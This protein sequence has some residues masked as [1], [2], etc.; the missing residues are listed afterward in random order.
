LEFPYGT[1]ILSRKTNIIEN[2][3]CYDTSNNLQ[4]F[5]NQILTPITKIQSVPSNF[6]PYNYS[7]TN[8][9][10]YPPSHQRIIS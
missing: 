9:I 1:K 10:Y 3:R 8:A 5:Q 2:K 6:Q 4:H 7:Q